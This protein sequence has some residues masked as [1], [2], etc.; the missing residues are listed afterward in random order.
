MWRS[1]GLQH[2][3]RVPHEP[4][5]V[6]M[7]DVAVAR[8]PQQVQRHVVRRAS[9][10]RLERLLAVGEMTAVLPQEVPDERLRAAPVAGVPQERVLELASDPPDVEYPVAALHPLQ[11]DRRDVHAVAE[12]EVR[13]GRVTVQTDLPVLPYQRAVPPAVPQAAA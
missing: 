10:N 6:V 11:V 3:L 12:Q 5:A 13:G 4:S 7:A 9:G 8:D 2:P 1:S